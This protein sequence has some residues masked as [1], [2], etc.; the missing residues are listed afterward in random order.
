MEI[1]LGAVIDGRINLREI[2]KFVTP[3]ECLQLL[4]LAH[5][6]GYAQSKVMT[7]DG[8]V[9]HSGRTSSSCALMKGHTPLVRHLEEIVTEITGCAYEDI[10]P[11]QL[12]KYDQYERYDSHF[13]YLD[14][15]IASEEIASRGQRVMTILVYLNVPFSGG[16]TYFPRLDVKISPSLGDA[17][18]WE[19]CQVDQLGRIK[20]N[21]LSEHGGMPVTSGTKVALNIWIRKRE[22]ERKRV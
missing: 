22:S 12:V 8:F 11:F 20:E 6:V 13:D 7:S 18:M 10:E 19:N 3:V 17:V 9:N 21:P 14:A 16:E 1:E 2:K 15:E 5:E 4:N